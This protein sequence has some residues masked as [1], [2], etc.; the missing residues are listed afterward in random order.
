MLLSAG[1]VLCACDFLSEKMSVGCKHVC[2]A[3]VYVTSS[4]VLKVNVS[5]VERIRDNLRAKLKG[6]ARLM[7]LRWHEECRFC[8]TSVMI[9]P[10]II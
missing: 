3:T 6:M 5:S 2:K 10:L 9:L 7:C 8:Q 4:L 1:D